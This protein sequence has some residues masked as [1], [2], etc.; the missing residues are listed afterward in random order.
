MLALDKLGCMVNQLNKTLK[1]TGQE[2][3]QS[4]PLHL[5]YD[6]SAPLLLISGEYESEEY[7]RQTHEM[8]NCWEELGYQSEILVGKKL[9]HFNI[10]DNLIDPDSQFVIEQLRHFG[11]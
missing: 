8:Y 3:K 6:Y 7:R 4:S 1:M 2:A 10:V 9:N 5:N 11:C